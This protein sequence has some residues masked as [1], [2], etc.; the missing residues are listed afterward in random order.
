MEDTYFKP[1][2]NIKKALIL[3]WIFA[4]KFNVDVPNIEL[5]EHNSIKV[6]MVLNQ[7]NHT[8]TGSVYCKVIEPFQR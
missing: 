6:I 1:I 5:K 7:A 4:H 3:A 8:Y 2:H